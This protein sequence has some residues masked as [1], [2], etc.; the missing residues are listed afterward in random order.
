MLFISKLDFEF[1]LFLLN[2]IIGSFAVAYLHR[3]LD[4]FLIQYY[5]NFISYKF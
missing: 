1:I 5:E 4:P 3:I 2:F